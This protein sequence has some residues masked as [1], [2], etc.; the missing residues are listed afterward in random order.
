MMVTALKG[1]GWPK[2]GEEG[3]GIRVEMG[4]LRRENGSH[5]CCGHW[6]D[7]VAVSEL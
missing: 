7:E 6:L 4:A 1:S 2:F 3:L 5:F